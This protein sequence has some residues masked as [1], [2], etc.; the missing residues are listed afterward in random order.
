[1]NKQIAMQLAERYTSA[2]E[3]GIIKRDVLTN[4]GEN[5]TGGGEIIALRN[6]RDYISSASYLFT[7]MLA[8]GV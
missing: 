2:I 5:F 1:M 3:K 7:E 6:F 8:K 4:H